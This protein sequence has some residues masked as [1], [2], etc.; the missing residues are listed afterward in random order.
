LTTG[1]LRNNSSG[2]VEL[3]TQNRSMA[4]GSVTWPSPVVTSGGGAAT[5]NGNAIGVDTSGFAYVAG[6]YGS[7]SNGKD[8]VLL[9]YKVLDGS[10]LTTLYQNGVSSGSL[11][12][13]GANEFLDVAVDT[14]GTLYAVGYVTQSNLVSTTASGAVTSWWIG[15]YSP[16]GLVQLWTA[17][18]NFGVGNDRAISVSLSGNFVYVMGAETFTGPKTGTRVLKFVK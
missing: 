2:N 17:T 9:R 18:F 12:F 10:G 4:T 1:D 16:S 13:S 6:N 15:K 11:N 5:N 3:F 7:A 8:S 14:D